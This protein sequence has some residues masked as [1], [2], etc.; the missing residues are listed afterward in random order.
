MNKFYSRLKVFYA[1]AAVFL[2]IL[3][4]FTC[5]Y[6]IK[7][8]DWKPVLLILLAIIGISTIAI[9][10]LRYYKNIVIDISFDKANTIIKTNSHVFSLPSSKFIEVNDAKSLGKIFILYADEKGSQKFVFQKNILL[11]NH[12]L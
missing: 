6:N 9:G 11:L 10:I 7:D 2:S 1:V 12:I 4:I 3:F 5:I 8:G